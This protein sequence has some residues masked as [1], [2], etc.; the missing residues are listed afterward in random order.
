M[1]AGGEMG[2]PG[3]VPPTAPPPAA[4]APDARAATARWA[5]AGLVLTA[6][7][8]AALRAQLAGL[9][10]SIGPWF[11]GV[12]HAHSH[13]GFYAFIFPALWLAWRRAGRAAPGRAMLHA[14]CAVSLIAAVGF[15]W[16]GYWWPTIAASTF[17]G[18]VWLV[19]GLKNRHGL[20]RGDWH[21]A[22][23]PS[24]VVGMLLVPAIAVLTRRDPGLAQQIVRVFLSALLLGAALPALVGG[25]GVRALAWVGAA[26][27]AAVGG[28]LALWP[29]RL[30]G[31]V[32]LSALLVMALRRR[33]RAP[34]LDRD[35]LGVQWLLVAVGFAAY[36]TG[37]LPP[38]HN[39]AIAGVHFI[40]LG[41]V[42]TTLLSRLRDR[43]L[44]ALTWLYL[45]LVLVMCGAISLVGVALDGAGLQRVAAA[46]GVLIA[47]LLPVLAWTARR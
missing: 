3:P 34:G 35:L 7:I 37:L 2:S 10:L 15:A 44:P 9:D 28:G 27:A 41:P 36:G 24:I 20:L 5:I 47:A 26:L 14:Y 17:I 22:A 1:A 11:A 8:G 18:V 42:A 38:T 12:R 46:S 39:A 45:A 33:P 13:L 23:A 30:A 25:P 4:P 40:A 31:Y 21:A 6:A 32:A 29:L 16:R 43:P 19:Y